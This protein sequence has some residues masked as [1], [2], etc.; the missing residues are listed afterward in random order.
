MFGFWKPGP[1]VKVKVPCTPVSVPPLPIVYEHTPYCAVVPG[2]AVGFGEV[3]IE[4]PPSAE[5]KKLTRRIH[6]Q[7]HNIR[8]GNE[9]SDLRDITV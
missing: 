8:I 7:G 4:S 9:A 1:F 5:N 2:H 6:R 3:D